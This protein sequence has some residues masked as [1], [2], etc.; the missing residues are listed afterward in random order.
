MVKAKGFWEYLCVKLNYRLFAGVPC[1][2]LSSLYKTMNKD[3]LHYMPSV[4]ERIAIGIVSGG[5][6]AGFKGGV[7]LSA[8]SIAGLKNEIQI[9]KDFNIPILLIVYS[10]SNIKLPFWHKELSDNF[11]KDLD[12]ID[13]RKKPSVLLIKKGVLL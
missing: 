4:N 10:D 11:E 9:V 13:S 5:F 6:L 12:K 8:N 2:G 3:M 1:L 7:L